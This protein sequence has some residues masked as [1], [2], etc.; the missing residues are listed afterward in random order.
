MGQK[1]AEPAPASSTCFHHVTATVGQASNPN[2]QLSPSKGTGKGALP[3]DNE[4]IVVQGMGGLGLAC[5]AARSPDQSQSWQV[6]R[7]LAST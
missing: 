3:G 7:V 6:V 5:Y 2:R 4:T 1:D